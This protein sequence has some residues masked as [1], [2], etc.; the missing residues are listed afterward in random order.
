MRKHH[1]IVAAIAFLVCLISITFGIKIFNANA[2]HL[3]TELN[4]LDKVYYS[5]VKAVPQ[6]SWMAAVGTL[7]FL[8]AIMV[9]EVFILFKVKN[10]RTKNVNRGILFLVITVLVFDVLILM[11]PVY[12]DFSKWG[13][14]WICSGLL[15]VMGSAISYIQRRNEK[16]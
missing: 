3:I 14:I 9:F 8:L 12:Y 1:L 13:F 4:E 5:D 15:M 16:V 11:N 10:K 2:N 6:L 7:P